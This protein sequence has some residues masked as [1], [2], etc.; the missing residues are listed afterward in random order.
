MT[1]HGHG[2]STAA[3]G[4]E[5]V[6]KSHIPELCPFLLLQCTVMTRAQNYKFRLQ[7]L[8]EKNSQPRD[9]RS[10]IGCIDV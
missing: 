6:N 10:K 3:A 5:L 7:A 2:R 8:F 4:L 1:N 9:S